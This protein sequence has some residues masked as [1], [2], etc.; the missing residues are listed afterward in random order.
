MTLSDWRTHPACRLS[1]QFP[2][3]HVAKHDCE[4]SG[5]Y[6]SLGFGSGRE[7]RREPAF[8]D[9][10]QLIW[11]LGHC[12]TRVAHRAIQPRPGSATVVGQLETSVP[13]PA[14]SPRQPGDRARRPPARV[15][16]PGDDTPEHR[17]RGGTRPSTVTGMGVDLVED[18]R[19]RR[20]C[21]LRRGMRCASEQQRSSRARAG[22]SAL[23]NRKRQ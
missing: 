22:Q 3:T 10:K 14:R 1:D 4:A 8:L 17:P 19:P 2:S 11:A 6:L 5:A 9:G 18:P 7:S 23:G 21:G 13:L 20:G 15:G 12:R 16:E